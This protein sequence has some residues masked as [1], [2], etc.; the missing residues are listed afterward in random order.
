MRSTFSFGK[1]ANKLEAIIVEDLNVKGRRINKAIQDGIDK[2][3]NIKGEKYS[4]IAP[5]KQV[6][7]D[8]GGKKLLNRTGKMRGT[9]LI[10]SKPNNLKFI[11]EMRTHY[12]AYHNTGFK[13]TN[14]K[15][16]FY[17]SK[18]PKREWFGVPK[19]MMP[20]GSEYKKTEPERRLRIRTAWKN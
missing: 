10:P 17:G 18:V 1:L 19:T 11:I 6:T 3:E 7:R 20:G 8:L 16:W 5:M 12:G 15:Q 4:S 2:E 9:K 13:Q 14:P